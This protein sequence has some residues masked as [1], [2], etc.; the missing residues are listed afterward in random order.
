MR[1]AFGFP[2][3]VGGIR[4]GAVNFYADRPGRLTDDQHAD[5]LVM[6]DVAAEAVLAMQVE[7]RR[8]ASPTS[9]SGDRTPVRGPPGRGDG[10]CPARHQGGPALLRLR[11]YAF[12][13]QR[14]L[15]DVATEVVARHLRFSDDE[16]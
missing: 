4:L 8:R 9:S 1:A 12:A 6:A 3:V 14:V 2:M 15:A 5:A 10:F 13:R 11:S 16:I 7:G